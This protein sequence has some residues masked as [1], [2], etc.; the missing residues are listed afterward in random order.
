ML[1]PGGMARGLSPVTGR[2][3]WLP[4]STGTEPLG[5][6]SR[7]KVQG[8]GDADRQRAVAPGQADRRGA[9]GEPTLEVQEGPCREVRFSSGRL[10]LP[11]GSCYRGDIQNTGRRAQTAETI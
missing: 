7:R 4:F 9:G 11:L 1:P 8:G 2:R 10:V 6:G 3:I 5:S